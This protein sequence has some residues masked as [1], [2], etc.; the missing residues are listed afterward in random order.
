VASRGNTQPLLLPNQNGAISM[1]AM[2]IEDIK[3]SSLLHVQSDKEENNKII[4]G[5][6]KNMFQKFLVYADKVPSIIW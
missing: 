2:Q 5:I 6:L 1:R 4:L 3:L